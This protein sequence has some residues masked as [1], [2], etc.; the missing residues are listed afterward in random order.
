MIYPSSGAVETLSSLNNWNNI[1]MDIEV[2]KLGLSNRQL[3]TVEF[4]LKTLFEGNFNIFSIIL[5][6][7]VHFKNIFC[8]FEKKK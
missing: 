3:Y 1:H 8:N 7:F 2:L 6:L 4:F 5:M